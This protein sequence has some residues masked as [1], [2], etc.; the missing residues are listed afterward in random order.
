MLIFRF[1]HHPLVLDMKRSSGVWPRG[2]KNLVGFVRRPHLLSK[3]SSTSTRG[4]AFLPSVHKT[5]KQH[6]IHVASASMQ[7]H[8]MTLHR[9]C[10]DV[11]AAL[12]AR[13]VTWS[14]F[15]FER[16][17]QELYL[18]T[19]CAHSEDVQVKPQLQSTLVI[20]TSLTSNNRLSRSENLVP[21]LT[22]R[23]INRQ[24]N[25][26]EKRI[27]FPQY[28]QYIF[29]S[30]VKLHIHSVK[31]SSSINCFPQFRKSDMSK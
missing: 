21:V 2:S 6:R 13:L 26:V 19:I 11:V 31:G 24:Q 29:N 10:C 20:S 9:R 28:F 23:S 7:R 5:L 4:K 1:R 14:K 27:Y 3:K 15:I 22:Q 8:V 17:C 18:R 12:C 30:G 25:I 16:H